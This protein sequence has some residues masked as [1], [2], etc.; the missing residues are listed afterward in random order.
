MKLPALSNQHCLSHCP[1][2][3]AV[4]GTED[5]MWKSLTPDLIRGMNTIGEIKK[6][7]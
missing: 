4:A 5:L 3:I 7:A 6:G 2:G 1:A